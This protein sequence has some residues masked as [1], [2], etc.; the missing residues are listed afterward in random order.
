MSMGQ[1]DK[2]IFSTGVPSLKM[3]L[4]DVKLT[5]NKVSQSKVP[6]EG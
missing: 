1:S 3:T 2:G 4:S 6:T 5:Q